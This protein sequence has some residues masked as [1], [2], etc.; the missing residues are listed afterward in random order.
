MLQRRTS[1]WTICNK[2]MEAYMIIKLTRPYYSILILSHKVYKHLYI[3]IVFLVM[4]FHLMLIIVNPTNLFR[5]LKTLHELY[6]F[7]K[8]PMY[9]SIAI[10]NWCMGY[11]KNFYREICILYDVNVRWFIITTLTFTLHIPTRRL[12]LAQVLDFTQLKSAAKILQC[13]KWC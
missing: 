8:F 12:M 5:Y 11:W 7:M 4:N 10:L 3:Y 6:I 9:N 1:D 2:T 13:L